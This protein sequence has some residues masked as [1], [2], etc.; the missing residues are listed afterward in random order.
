MLSREYR[1][2]KWTSTVVANAYVGPIVSRYLGDLEQRLQQAGFHGDLI[3]M[4]SNSELS[5]IATA[6]R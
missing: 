4:Q 5:D 1:E 3:I 6:R 2:Y